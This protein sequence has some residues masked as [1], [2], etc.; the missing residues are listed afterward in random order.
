MNE[1]ARPSRKQKAGIAAA[2]IGQAG[3]LVEFWGEMQPELAEE[4]VTAEMARQCLA[5][6]LSKLPGDSWD[7]RLDG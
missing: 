5:A 1:T 7:V 4:G 2:L 6:W 3:N